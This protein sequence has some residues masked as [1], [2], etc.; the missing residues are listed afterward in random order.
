MPEKLQELQPLQI[1]EDWETERLDNA[2]HLH[3]GGVYE[4]TEAIK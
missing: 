1:E 2:E 4:K 3:D